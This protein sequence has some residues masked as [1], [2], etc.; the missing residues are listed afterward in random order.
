MEPTVLKLMPPKENYEILYNDLIKQHEILKKENENINNEL[1]LLKKSDFEY[2]TINESLRNTIK[3]L[4]KNLKTTNVSLIKLQNTTNKQIKCLTQNKTRVIEKKAKDF[5]SEIFTP[6]QLDLIMKKKTGTLDTR[7]I[8]K[9]FYL[10]IFQQ[11]SLC[12]CQ[13]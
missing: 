6:N 1:I 7:R 2:R 9:S 11:A 10:K 8:S 4:Q 12:I 3:I 13:E 5:L